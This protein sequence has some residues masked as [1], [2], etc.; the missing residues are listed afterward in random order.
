MLKVVA[1]KD[2]IFSILGK[3]KV[4]IKKGDE[5]YGREAEDLIAA[6]YA[7][8]P[9]EAMAAEAAKREE[10][11]LRQAAL[12][13]DAEEKVK[14]LNDAANAAAQEAAANP[15]DSNKKGLATKATN[16]LNKAIEEL[17]ALKV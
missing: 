3:R 4:N 11:Q 15:E 5:F 10:E 7:D 13:A 6:G 14:K 9:R 16:A 1:K 12:L 17:N 2:G 8:D